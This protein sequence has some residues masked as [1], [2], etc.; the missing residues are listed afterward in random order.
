MYPNFRR[1]VGKL[2]SRVAE[3][4]PAFWLRLEPEP[5]KLRSSGCFLTLSCSGR[6]PDRF[7]PLQDRG[8]RAQ[9]HQRRVRRRRHR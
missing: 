7:P 5:K 4:E 6:Q 1:Y 3:P 9:Q 2:I 8:G